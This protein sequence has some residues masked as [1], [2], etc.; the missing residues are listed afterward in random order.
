[1]TTRSSSPFRLHH[2][3]ITQED[4]FGAWVQTTIQFKESFQVIS[5]QITSWVITMQSKGRWPSEGNLSSTKEVVRLELRG[6]WQKTQVISI[7][8]EVALVARAMAHS[9][10]L[11]KRQWIQEAEVGL[12]IQISLHR[13]TKVAFSLCNSNRP[14]TIKHIVSVPEEMAITMK[15]YRAWKMF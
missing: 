10:I 12:S 11:S 7:M 9:S 13:W 2:G 6:I 1:M 4:I 3:T 15:K 5:L 14:P 8:M